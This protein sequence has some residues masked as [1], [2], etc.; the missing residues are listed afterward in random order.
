MIL[1]EDNG[2]DTDED[3]EIAI[4]VVVVGNG[5]V[6]KSSMI[7]RFCK[8]IFTNKYKKTI[9]VDFLEKHITASGEDVRLMLWD[10]AGQEEFDAITRAYYRGAQACV[11]VFSTID[12]PS[13]AA[14]KKW[15]RKV[16]DE[17]GHIPMVLVQNKIDLLHETQVDNTE[18]EKFARNMGLKLFRTSVK[19]NLNVNK[20]FQ[21]LAE[22]HIESVSRWSNEDPDRVE[23]GGFFGG[24]EG[25]RV[26]F[27]GGS[28]TILNGHESSRRIWSSSSPPTM[29]RQLHHPSCC[30]NRNQKNRRKRIHN[31]A[32]HSACKMI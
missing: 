18:I 3:Y 17:C 23:I 19:E 8:G 27:A 26:T 20:V 32:F 2:F 12:R 28:P 5:A 11:I 15:K 13:F 21:L 30:S 25:V 7:Q 31:N 10:T 29:H 6:G 1:G 4:K 14:V 9:G 24:G 16:E 22:R